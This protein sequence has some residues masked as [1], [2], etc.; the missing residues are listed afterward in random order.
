MRYIT[1][2]EDVMNRIKDIFVANIPTMI[3]ACNADKGDSIVPAFL[4]ET[5][6]MWRLLEAP[7]YA[8]SYLLDIATDPEII[9]GGVG[10]VV[11]I[12]TLRI[13][14][15]IN[16]DF[17]TNIPLIKHRLNKIFKEILYEKVSRE[18]STLKVLKEDSTLMPDEF[19]FELSSIV[20]RITL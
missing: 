8:V 6:Y 13:T 2:I 11:E 18:Y 9:N 16:D 12:Y 17:T 10:E 5:F 4:S 7:P 20:F 15:I 14:S 19:P 3:T 1:D